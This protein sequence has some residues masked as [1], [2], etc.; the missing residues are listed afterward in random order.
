MATHRAL[1]RDHAGQWEITASSPASGPYAL[2][3]TVLDVLRNPT[4]GSP[5]YAPMLLVG[6]DKAYGDVYRTPDEVFQAPWYEWIEGLLPGD[7]GG[8]A[9]VDAGLLPA[10]LTGPGGLLTEAFVNGY[11]VDA[12]LPAR[13]RVAQNDLLGWIP[14]APMKLCGG[15]RDEV[16]PFY[17]SMLAQASFRSMGAPVDLLD[18]EED[19][20]YGPLVS[21]L[22]RLGLDEG[23]Y[24]GGVVSLLC[25]SYAKRDVFDPLR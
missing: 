23:G 10:T 14:R 21:L 15:S 13:Q 7:T 4:Y 16:V 24:H 17:N 6:L 8:G 5:A 18:I 19:S 9:L 25:A 22:R 20:V 1:E 2:S 11:L 12:H 3:E